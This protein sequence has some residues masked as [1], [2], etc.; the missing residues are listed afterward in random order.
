MGQPSRRVLTY[1]AQRFLCFLFPFLFP[2]EFEMHSVQRTVISHFRRLR[3]M[4][5][6]LSKEFDDSVDRATRVPLHHRLI[7]CVIL[8]LAVQAESQGQDATSVA[9]NEIKK[10]AKAAIDEVGPAIVRFSYGNEHEIHFG[11]G[12]IVTADGHVAISGPVRAVLDDKLLAM[13]LHDGRRVRGR[14]LGWSSEN[15]FGILKIV[16]GG[17]WPHV[18]L[19]KQVTVGDVCVALGFQRNSADQVENTSPDIRLGLVTQSSE[20]QW[21][22][23]SHRSEFNAHPVFDLNGK[24]LGLACNMPVGDDPILVSASLIT[25]HWDDLIAGKNLDRVR[26]FSAAPVD[27]PSKA[28]K[29]DDEVIAK[30]K[31]ASVVINLPGKGKNNASG[32]IVTNDGYVLTC[33][34]HER[35]PGE[36]L[37]LLLRDGRSASAI[38]LGSNLISDIG[39]LKITDDG[40]WPYAEMG[41][42]AT[43]NVGTPCVLI[44]YPTRLRKKEPWIFET[45]V[46][47]P[48]Q[49]LP[50][51]DKWHCQFWTAGYPDSIGGASGGGV[52]NAQ[53]R[54]IG[55]VRGGA[56]DEMQHS[57]VELF[58]KNW[59]ALTANTPVQMAEPQLVA[60][61][62]AK[63]DRVAVEL[64]GH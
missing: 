10:L 61:M 33:G 2:K 45:H 43:T 50:S 52:F 64:S 34:H 21:L 31:A 58:R 22:R 28:A 36:K 44:G 15:G 40:P 59:M 26:L 60:G 5:P 12:V 53:G 38:V 46:I 7:C 35:M 1:M 25:D 20:G 17:P 41:R 48:T 49:T 13:R 23:T 57:R 55:V 16:E 63:L 4:R 30:A 19:N 3:R 42:S 54:V 62:K 37:D 32:V 6:V 56:G 47:E 11:C 8:A 29:V 9:S 24:L 27:Q 14:A 18:E 39:V 51:R